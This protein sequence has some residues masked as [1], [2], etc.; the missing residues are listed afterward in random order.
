MRSESTK[1][2]LRYLLAAMYALSELLAFR[3]ENHISDD[4]TIMYIRQQRGKKGKVKN[5]LKT[6]AA[7]RDIDL[8][9]HLP[10]C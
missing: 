5:T 7:Y 8:C 2:G 1:R 6:D 10:G 9:L 4:R 3:I